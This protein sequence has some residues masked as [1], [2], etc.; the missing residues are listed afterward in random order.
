MSPEQD[1][2]GPAAPAYLPAAD[3]QLL[4]SPH[5]AVPPPPEAVT[6]TGQR[7]ED[8]LR[9]LLARGEELLGAQVRMR[10]LLDAVV[11]LGADLSL[12]VVLERIVQSACLLV[13]AEYGALGVVGPD[14]RLA[15]FVTVGVDE[16]VRAQI[17]D[18]PHGRGLLGQLIEDPQALRLHDIGEHPA[19]YGLPPGHP[20]MRSFLGV[21]V[22]VRGRVF[23]NLYLTEKQGGA[24]FTAEDEDL[25][26]ALAAAAGI[27]IDNAGLYE[28]SRRRQDWLAAVVDVSSALLG[29]APVQR[30]LALVA[31]RAREVAVADVVAVALPDAPVVVDG[32]GETG[33]VRAAAEALRSGE[34]PAPAPDHRLLVVALPSAGPQAGA[35]A[36]A[37]AATASPFDAADAALLEGFAAQAAVA[38][39]LGRSQE[40]RGR[41]SLLEDRDRIARDLHDLV[42]QRLFATGLS[43]QGLDARVADGPVRERL[44]RAVDELD[45]TVREIR[46]AIFALRQDPLE[47]GAGLRAV[48][49]ELVQAA[50]HSLGSRPSLHVDG[51]VDHVVPETLVGEVRA[52][53]SE[54]LSNIARHA[55]ATS[56][57]VR[58]STDGRVLTVAVSDDGR[59]FDA[60]GHRSGLGNLQRRAEQLGGTLEVSSARDEGT[61]LVWQVPLA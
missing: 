42:I 40:D 17:G 38:L 58:V 7:L 11:A 23:G 52:V 12:P 29:G 33:P 57:G 43:L 47:A 45:E 54:G 24:D 60:P 53:V 21:P 50:S 35:L 22:R 4:T 55:R 56:A 20:P 3:T 10:G 61:Q 28:A 36:A 59:G 44:G 8:L 5:R 19:S 25:V 34:Q 27:A 32:P 18:P 37:R 30:A 51:P 1:E 6:A 49:H 15:Q 14:R 46:R 26:L 2:P 41:L 39:Q 13:G 48:L 31:A 16:A 9:E